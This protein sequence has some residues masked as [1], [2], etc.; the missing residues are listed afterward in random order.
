MQLALEK[1]KGNFDF[2]TASNDHTSALQDLY[3]TVRTALESLG[4]GTLLVLDDLTS[5]LWAGHSSTDVARLLTGLRALSASV[6]AMRPD[7][8]WPVFLSKMSCLT[9]RWLSRCS[10]LHRSSF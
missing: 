2:I 3:E 1:Q 9:L 6:S 10:M 8:V 5:L 4:P 7:H